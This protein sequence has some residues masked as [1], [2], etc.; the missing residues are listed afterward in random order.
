MGDV[1]LF[2]INGLRGDSFMR[3]VVKGQPDKVVEFSLKSCG[4][5][6]C[7]LANDEPIL[8]IIGGDYKGGFIKMLKLSR[9]FLT[10]SGFSADEGCDMEKFYVRVRY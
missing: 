2:L 8:E 1:L 4:D 10:K 5:F 6:I 3:Y 7:L 9:E